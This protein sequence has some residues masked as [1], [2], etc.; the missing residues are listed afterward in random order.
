MQNAGQGFSVHAS[1]ACQQC[2]WYAS[3]GSYVEIDRSWEVASSPELATE[4]DAAPAPKTELPTWAWILTGCVS[5]VIIES[6]A[7]R[8]LTPADSTIRTYWSLTQL[9]VGLV[10]FGVCHTICFLMVMKSEGETSLFDYFLRPI[11]SWSMLFRDLPKRQWA[12]YSGLSG[13]AAAMMSVLLI[14]GLPYER[15]LDWDFKKKPKQSLIGAMMSQAQKIESDDE[16][17]LEEAIGDL[18]GKAG[19]EEEKKKKKKKPKAKPRLEEDCVILGYMTN[20]A[21]EIQ[22]LL[23]GAEHR[24]KF[25]YAGNVRP[26]NLSVEERQAL[27]QKLSDT[28][29]RRPFV[30]MSI[31]GAIWVK[32]KYLCRVSFRRRGK[33]GGMFGAQLEEMTGEADLGG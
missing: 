20:Q 8:L 16:Q 10:A 32:P 17:S 27:T 33:Q 11:K 2:G 14:G 31:D 5:A 22:N 12:C 21:G 19:L 26:S 6:V 4:A 13:L 29:T 1:L 25:R 15:L 30:K 23:I 24:G 7:V 9:F 3:I 28:K 18:A